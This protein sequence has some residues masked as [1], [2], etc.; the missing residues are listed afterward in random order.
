[1]MVSSVKPMSFLRGGWVPQPSHLGY[2]ESP[3]GSADGSPSEVR[4][5]PAEEEYY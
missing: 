1:M 3:I 2:S 5:Y 4:R